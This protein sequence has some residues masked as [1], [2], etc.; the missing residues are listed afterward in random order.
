MACLFLATWC[1]CC[2]LATCWCRRYRSTWSQLRRFQSEHTLVHDLQVWT[3]LLVFWMHS[4]AT[5]S[6]KALFQTSLID[7]NDF[8]QSL[9]MHVASL[10][11]LMFVVSF[12]VVEKVPTSPVDIGK[13][14]CKATFVLARVHVSTARSDFHLCTCPHLP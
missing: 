10:L 4:R 3:D 11:S 13:A 6:L 14:L 12:F 7:I 1:H 9:F 5:L 2:L 8:T